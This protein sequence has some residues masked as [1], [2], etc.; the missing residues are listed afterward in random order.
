MNNNEL[1][2]IIN[3]IGASYLISYL[4][5]KYID[6]NHD[7][8][9]RR[10]TDKTALI[11]SNRKFFYDMVQVILQ[12]DE[13]RLDSNKIGLSGEEVK[14]M[15]EE[16][17]KKLG[18]NV[19]VSIHIKSKD[20]IALSDL[21]TCSSMIDEGFKEYFKKYNGK[22]GYS[23]NSGEGFIEEFP[24]EAFDRDI[25]VTNVR[26]GSIWIDLLIKIL[27]GAVKAFFGCLV[28]KLFDKHSCR[29]KPDVRVIIININADTDYEIEVYSENN[30]IEINIKHKK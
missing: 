18:G 3:K 6:K 1:D 30:F 10:E 12:M 21:A 24:A 19:P 5:G 16:L 27:E 13:S 7:N 26:D 15:A 20:Y 29:E 22:E 8:Y 14:R 11:E 17:L 28:K 4:Y 25:V 23:G 2:E 9:K